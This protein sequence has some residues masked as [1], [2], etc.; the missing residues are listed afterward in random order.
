MHL[1]QRKIFFKSLDFYGLYFIDIDKR[2]LCPYI[3]YQYLKMS[4]QSFILII[5][6]LCRRAIRN[7]CLTN[8]EYCFQWKLLNTFAL[9]Y[10]SRFCL[11]QNYQIFTINIINQLT[12]VSDYHQNCF[13]WCV[14]CTEENILDSYHNL[15]YSENLLNFYKLF[16]FMNQNIKFIP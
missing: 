7:E 3:S 6:F 14:Y 4:W 1:Q 8:I 10:N 5:I 11:R 2:A 9:N 15:L 13:D 12:F 16:F